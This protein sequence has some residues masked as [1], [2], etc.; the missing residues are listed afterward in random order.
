[1]ANNFIS[2]LSIGVLVFGGIIGIIILFA[3][4]NAAGEFL[5]YTT[6][7]WGGI[8]VCFAV[9][10]AI[11]FIMISVVK[12]HS[13]EETY[14]TNITVTKIGDQYNVTDNE[15]GEPIQYTSVRYVS[16]EKLKEPRIKEV[17]ALN[18]FNKVIL[19]GS[20]LEIP[21]EE[22]RITGTDSKITSESA[23]Q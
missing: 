15:T 7:P 17:R 5:E 10:V 19:S 16:N 21:I 11:I 3:L 22:E 2:A 8:F 9:I 23:L 14:I 13:K 1:M 4:I 12:V 18:I 20:V 6:G